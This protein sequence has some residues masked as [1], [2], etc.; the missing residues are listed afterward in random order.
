MGERRPS[1]QEKLEQIRKQV[2]DRVETEKESSGVDP[3]G[4]DGGGEI[5]SRFIRDC[6]RMNELGDGLLFRELHRGKFVFNKA[7]DQWM[8]WVGHHWEIDQMDLAKSAVEDVVGA[9]IDETVRVA[10]EMK[11]LEEGSTA[12][13]HLKDLRDTL[14]K[15]VWALRSTRRRANCLTMAHTCEDGLAIR[16]DELDQN[17]WL[18]ACSNCVIDLRTGKSRDGRP[19]DFILKASDVEWK[20]VDEPCG[21][22]LDFMY[23]VFEEDHLDPEEEH[24]VSDFMQ[25]L[26]GYAILGSDMLHIFP[27]WTGIGRNGKGTIVKVMCHIMGQMADTLRPEMLLD[28][29]RNANAGG[30]TPHIIALRGLRMA[31]ASETNEGCKISAAEV[32][33]L[34]GGDKLKARS[35]HDKYEVSFDPTHTLFLLTNVLPHAPA[36]DFALWERTL[37]VNFPL[38]FVNRDPE[39]ENERRADLGLFDKLIEHDSGILAWLVKGCLMWQKHGL[40]PPPKV[41][42]DVKDYRENED[43]LGAFIDYCC[44]IDEKAW[45][46][47]TQL[48]NAFEEWWKKFISSKSVAI[49]QKKFGMMMRK[50]FTAEKIGGVY[51]YHGLGLLE[52][53]RIE[54]PS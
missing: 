26:L 3:K 30:P 47:A 41:L 31:F 43:N 5:T 4:G 35:P 13:S 33:R 9:Y 40:N 28:Q 36:D 46:G 42:I 2:A 12:Y 45:V 21:P 54:D 34:T 11:D 37:V 23:M 14:N 25:R 24:P 27:V 53:D 32:K 39:K 15:R 20:G 38:S 50:R 48:Y 16:G 22:W 19:E 29:N 51:R 49:K 44:Y 18:L 52:Q 7:M 8:V 1:D 6:L 17:Q 10:A